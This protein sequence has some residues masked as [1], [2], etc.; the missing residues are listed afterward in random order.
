MSNQRDQD[1]PEP[2]NSRSVRLHGEARGGRLANEA[3]TI[4]RR[5]HSAFT[6]TTFPTRQCR[7][8][9]LSEWHI[10]RMHCVEEAGKKMKERPKGQEGTNRVIKIQNGHIRGVCSGD[11]AKYIELGLARADRAIHEPG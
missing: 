10:R 11:P 7:R 9:F 1:R 2:T 4:E 6:F 3:G 5:I 8:S